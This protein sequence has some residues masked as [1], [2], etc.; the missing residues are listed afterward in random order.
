[1]PVDLSVVRDTPKRPDVEREICFF[2]LVFWSELVV[3]M[4]PFPNIGSSRPGWKD[5]QGGWWQDDE[6]PSEAAGSAAAAAAGIATGG[7]GGRMKGEPKAPKKAFMARSLRDN[8]NNNNNKWG[9]RGS[10]PYRPQDGP[11][12][13]RRHRRDAGNENNN[14]YDN[15]G[16]AG[17]HF[18]M[19][20]VPSVRDN[21]HWLG[22]G[23]GLLGSRGRLY[24]G[25]VHAENL[26]FYQHVYEGVTK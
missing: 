18:S 2:P 3:D 6:F 26:G 19:E 1:M 11:G 9:G 5:N 4:N 7:G 25:R 21:V 10:P 23:K 17:E 12:W 16:G 22:Q 24:M 8:N 13:A 14:Y 15:G 20:I